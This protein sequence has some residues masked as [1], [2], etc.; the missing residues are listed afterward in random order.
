MNFQTALP[1]FTPVDLAAVLL[2]W[3]GWFVIGHLVDN[4]KS[5]KPS[6]SVLMRRYRREWMRQFVTRQPRIFDA[7]ILSSLRQGTTFFASACMIALGGGMALIGNTE[8]LSG[9]AEDFTFETAPD[10]VW[11]V[12][13]GMALIFVVNAFLKF[14]WAHR[15]F[16]YCAVVMAA[17]PNDHDNPAVYARAAQAAELNIS[18][19]R[20]YNRGLRSVYFALAA[21]TWLLG[22]WVLLLATVLTLSFLWRR[23]FSSRSRTVLLDGLGTLST[24][25][26]E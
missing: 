10:I 20:S 2:I 23:E 5:H 4:A 17:V 7:T 22:A 13:I 24:E 11:E 1:H 9:V 14:V 15:L 25:P 16:G 3:G 18:A 12:K 8:R 26:A 6:V 21:L 19:A